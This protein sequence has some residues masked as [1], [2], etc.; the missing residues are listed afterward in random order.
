M[1][2]SAQIDAF[3]RFTRVSRETII[4]LKIFEDMLINTNK[5]LNLIGKST[6]NDIWSRPFFR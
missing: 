5:N 4:S 3:S 2:K 1:D 6:I